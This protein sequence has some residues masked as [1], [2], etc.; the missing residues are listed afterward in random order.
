MLLDRKIRVAAVQTFPEMFDLAGT[1][2]KT[3]GWMA[4]G[5][6]QGAELLVFPETFISAYP[7]WRGHESMKESIEYIGKMQE[8]AVEVP[9]SAVDRLCKGAKK[10]KVNCVIGVNELDRENGACTIYNSQLIISRSGRLVGVRRK[11]MPT[12]SERVYW[13]WGQRDDIFVSELDIGRVGALICYEHHLGLLGS[14]MG[15]LGEEIH[16]AVWPGWWDVSGHLGNKTPSRERGACD[17]EPITRAYAIHNGV[18]VINCCPYAPSDVAS[19]AW[20][21]AYLNRVAVGG[22]NIISPCGTYVVEPN[23]SGECLVMGEIDLKERRLNKGFF[24]AYG[25]YSRYDP[26]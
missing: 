5:E 18:F 7:Y 4:A 2:E 23:F 24:D 25:H 13:G 21:G 22:S 14:A 6:K 3:E 16:C 20:S 11:L 10:H 17:I 12:H 9:S 15:V 19:K 1:L 8:S 26:A